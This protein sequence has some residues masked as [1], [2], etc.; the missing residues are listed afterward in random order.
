MSSLT[1]LGTLGATSL[2]ARTLVWRFFVQNAEQVKGDPNLGGFLKGLMSGFASKSVLDKMR[3][4]INQ[5]VE[6]HNIEGLTMALKQG[7]DFGISNY[8]ILLRGGQELSSF[9]TEFANV[10]TS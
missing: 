5:I 4:N 8:N 7:Y 1:M 3:E 6:E 10:Y 2:K 9:L